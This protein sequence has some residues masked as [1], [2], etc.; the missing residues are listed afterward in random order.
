MKSLITKCGA[1]IGLLRVDE[2]DADVRVFALLMSLSA[3]VELLNLSKN[4]EYF[5]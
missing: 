3:I 1:D 5:D 4:D 2:E